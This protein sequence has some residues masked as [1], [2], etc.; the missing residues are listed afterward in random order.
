MSPISSEEEQTLAARGRPRA[1]KGVIP[2]SSRLVSPPL[3]RDTSLRELRSD[4][5]SLSP[6]LIGTLRKS[7]PLGLQLLPEGN[8]SLRVYYGLNTRASDSDI[9][10]P[11]RLPRLIITYDDPVSD[12]RG[13]FS[14]PSILSWSQTDGRRASSSWPALNLPTGDLGTAEVEGLFDL[15]Q[16][17][18]GSLTKMPAVYRR[19]CMWSARSA[20]KPSSNNFPPKRGRLRVTNCCCRMKFAQGQS[21]WWMTMGA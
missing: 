1:R 14:E 7:L 18:E 19:G 9:E 16:V 17:A 5:V 10:H 6:I 8:A 11:E 4:S 3:P 21:W 20:P 12:D 13:I 15:R 2:A